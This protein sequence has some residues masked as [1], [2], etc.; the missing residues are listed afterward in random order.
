MTQYYF[1]PLLAYV[2]GSIP[3]GLIFSEVFGRGKLRTTGS[4]NIG[5]TN[6]MRTQGKILGVLT[7]LSDFLKGLIPCYFLKTDNEIL[8]L[9]ILAAP[10]IGHI[11][12]IWLKFK[13]GKGIATWF[14]ILYALS[15]F[16]CISTAC[17]WAAMFAVTGVSAAAGLT[18]IAVGLGIFC[19]TGISLCWN[20]LNQLYVLMGLVVLIFLRHRENIGRLMKKGQSFGVD[21]ESSRKSEEPGCVIKGRKTGTFEA[22]PHR[23]NRSL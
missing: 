15:P 4:K 14:G 13:G 6:V 22:G 3:F 23:V 9:A 19:Y 12:P 16:V 17:I 5:A 2:S 1:Y 11:F 18:S 21:D 10:V 7:F 20:F 8:N